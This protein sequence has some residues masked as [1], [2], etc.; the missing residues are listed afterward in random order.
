MANVNLS[1]QVLPVVKEADIYPVV[2]KVIEL[3]EAS[4]VKYEVGAM[5]TTMEGEFDV[6]LDIVKK[7]QDICINEG[8]SRV[9]SVVKIDYKKEGVTMDEKTYKYRK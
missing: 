3:I 6:L 5:E 8:A 9:I 7:S 2:D 4:G 1:L